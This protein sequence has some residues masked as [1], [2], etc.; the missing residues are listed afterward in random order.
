SID[1]TPVITTTSVAN[2]AVGEAY[3]SSLAGTGVDDLT[4]A[5]SDAPS[6]LHLDPVTGALTG[7]P[8]EAGA[9]TFTATIGS[10]AGPGL[11]KQFTF[12]VAAATTGGGSGGSGGSSG[13]TGGGNATTGGNGT[14]TGGGSGSNAGSTGGGTL[15]NTGAD[16]SAMAATGSVAALVLL[17]GRLLTSVRRRF[18]TQGSTSR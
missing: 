9:V 7:T 16:S 11:A 8:T 13:T 4:F 3:S 10:P 18:R 2:G 5:S 15:A 6:W 12:T 17:A 14:G 1:L